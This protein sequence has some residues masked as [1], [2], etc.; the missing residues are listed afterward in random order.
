MIIP[1]KAKQVVLRSLMSSPLNSKSKK[2]SHTE[3]SKSSSKSSSYRHNKEHKTEKPR[4]EEEE[5]K[6]NLVYVKRDPDK[7]L[8]RKRVLQVSKTN[9]KSI[10][11]KEAMFKPINVASS[12]KYSLS[13]KD[14]TSGGKE[15]HEYIKKS[16]SLHAESFGA[17]PR[18]KFPERY[19]SSAK[20]PGRR[21]S[22]TLEEKLA[23]ISEKYKS[24]RVVIGSSKDNSNG[25]SK[26]RNTI[27]SKVNLINEKYKEKRQAIIE[28]K[29][30]SGM[31]AEKDVSYKSRGFDQRN[32]NPDMGKSRGDYRVSDQISLSGNYTAQSQLSSSNPNDV[33]GCLF[34]PDGSRVIN[35]F[36]SPSHVIVPSHTPAPQHP[37]GTAASQ[38][39]SYN[40]T[41]IRFPTNYA[42]NHLHDAIP[43]TDHSGNSCNPRYSDVP[44]NVTFPYL[45]PYFHPGLHPFLQ[46]SV[47]PQ[48]LTT[49][50]N[51]SIGQTVA[52]S[53]ATASHAS[54][55]N[56]KIGMKTD[57]D[58]VVRSE[59]CISKNEIKSDNDASDRSKPTPNNSDTHIENISGNKG[60]SS[61]IAADIELNDS[62]LAMKESD[63]E[64]ER[65]SRMQRI[66][67]PIP[68]QRVH[69]TDKSYGK[70][71][72][73][74]E[75]LSMPSRKEN[76]STDN[77]NECPDILLRNQSVVD[78]SNS[79]N[80]L[81]SKQNCSE[82]QLQAEDSESS[83][84]AR[85]TSMFAVPIE[86][87]IS[88]VCGSNTQSLIDLQGSGIDT[89]LDTDTES[90]RRDFYE[91]ARKIRG[92]AEHIDDDDVDSVSQRS[93]RNIMSSA[94]SQG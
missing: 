1:L 64:T 55:S 34:T 90:V 9:E 37:Y 54:P 32:I 73:A 5:F 33:M 36:V 44:T 28:N 56:G 75:N 45:F 50:T 35:R 60:A 84:A 8:T 2:F 11:N 77:I 29:G 38:N 22:E 19:S 71:K 69:I 18:T 94:S 7:K 31:E 46:S 66:D 49:G 14:L 48:G 43:V 61:I 51:D 86:D 42:V 88:G 16:P 4:N 85:E 41:G 82:G 58:A 30:I 79:T 72:N 78:A 65:V 24:Q 68:F 20:N 39:T 62:T 83:S 15:V 70:E 27:D 26:P 89:D 21:S 67:M 23:R 74:D 53:V 63:V 17:E 76:K 52:E 47:V 13:E 6:D 12:S 57:M 81:G 92:L 10:M 80:A 59:S 40:Q 25:T 91:K 93:Y 87:Y 3:N